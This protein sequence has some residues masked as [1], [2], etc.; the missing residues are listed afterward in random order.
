LSSPSLRTKISDLLR[1]LT[2][3]NSEESQRLPLVQASILFRP[4]GPPILSALSGSSSLP[5][6]R[7]SDPY[8]SFEL[9]SSS[10]LASF[11]IPPLFRA[12]VSYQVSRSCLPG[13]RRFDSLA[14][15]EIS[16]PT[17]RDFTQ[18]LPG[19]AG[20]PFRKTLPVIARQ[21]TLARVRQTMTL[22]PS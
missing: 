2:R 6:L 20:F 22:T 11:R 1:N 7:A 9:R 5:P 16:I 3:S 4:C 21:N 17:S 8:Y 19:I 14:N 18:L 12:S 15:S 10:T 13:L